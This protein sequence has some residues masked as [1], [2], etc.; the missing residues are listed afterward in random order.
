MNR[1][2]RAETPYK[3]GEKGDNGRERDGHQWERWEGSGL[4][5]SLVRPSRSRMWVVTMRSIS[6]RSR[7]YC[8]SWGRGRGEIRVHRGHGQGRPP[9]LSPELQGEGWEAHTECQQHKEEVWGPR[10][11]MAPSHRDFFPVAVVSC[12][13]LG[14]PLWQPQGQFP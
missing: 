12:L 3:S 2:R 5:C 14:P 8:W 6:S 10:K 7:G 13:T 1:E 9:H 4:T 11:L